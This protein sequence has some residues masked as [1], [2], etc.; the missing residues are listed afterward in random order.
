M[1]LSRCQDEARKRRNR[2]SAALSRKRKAE[3]VAG[4]EKNVTEFRDRNRDL[5]RSVSELVAENERLRKRLR[6][7]ERFLSRRR[8][9]ARA[10]AA[11]SQRQPTT[12]AAALV[13]TITPATATVASP[14]PAG[15]A[16]PSQVRV[17]APPAAGPTAAA[18]AA[19]SGLALVNSALPSLPTATSAVLPQEQPMR[20]VRMRTTEPE[21]A[22]QPTAVLPPSSS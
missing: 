8:A 3:Y 5:A 9:R 13:S 2:L 18:A 20:R 12:A 19:A 4:L 21:A 17:T 7:V 14:A 11:T 10:L 16:V 22:C 1:P 6:V 15:V